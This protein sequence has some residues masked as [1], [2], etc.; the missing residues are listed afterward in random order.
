MSNPRRTAASPPPPGGPAADPTRPPGGK[1][2]ASPGNRRDDAR[3]RQ[4][5]SGERGGAVPRQANPDTTPQ[6]EEA[7]GVARAP[8][9]GRTPYRDMK[10]PHEQDE[11]AGG[12]ATQAPGSASA[13][14]PIRQAHDDLVS[15]KQDTDCYDA[16][17]PRFE[18]GEEDDGAA[19]RPREGP[20]GRKPR[21]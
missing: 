6:E 9:E 19:P 12:Q 15:G 18:A 13:R 16:V 1:P 14:R 2:D 21:G 5:A 3:E 17:A 7:T 4:A 11:S 10:L 8:K 20:P